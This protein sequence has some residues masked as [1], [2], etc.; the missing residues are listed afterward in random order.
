MAAALPGAVA[1]DYGVVAS[2]NWYEGVASR[3]VAQVDDAAWVAV[4][5]SGAGGFAPAI[6]AAAQ[7]LAGVIFMDA[8]LPYPGASWKDT[9]PP[10][11]VARLTKLSTEGLLPTWDRW[12]GPDTLG[13][14]L[15]DPTA[16]AAFVAGLPR[17]PAAFLTARSPA[18]AWEHIPAAYLRLSD[19]YEAE[20]AEAERRGWPV[21]R[22]PLQHLAMVTDPDK[23]ADLLT[24]LCSSLAAR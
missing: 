15:P 23:V 22:A 5:H 8:V 13:R 21:L 1:V 16:R 6:A 2:P 7:R 20:A 19:G 10:A 18:D 24:Q 14:L 17:V 3:I 4:L 12:F 11:L 9:A